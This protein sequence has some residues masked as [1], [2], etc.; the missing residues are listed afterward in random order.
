LISARFLRAFSASL[1]RLRSEFSVNQ[2]PSLSSLRPIIF[3]LTRGWME[4]RRRLM[5]TEPCLG[6]DVRFDFLRENPA[7][8]SQLPSEACLERRASRG[9]HKKGVDAAG[10]RQASGHQARVCIFLTCFGS[11]SCLRAFQIDGRS[12]GR[13]VWMKP[14]ILLLIPGK[15]S[16]GCK[17]YCFSFVVS[18][19]FMRTFLAWL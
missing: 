10:N 12:T 7:V 15:T 9:T 17:S 11:G 1:I 4:L 16:N 6:D 14:E 2:K 19:P 13:S 5:K 18:R 3:S 8:K